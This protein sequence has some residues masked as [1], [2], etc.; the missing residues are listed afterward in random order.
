MGADDFVKRVEGMKFQEVGKDRRYVKA[1]KQ[2]GMPRM[3]HL[4]ALELKNHQ[5]L[6]MGFSRERWSTLLNDLDHYALEKRRSG[7][8]EEM[9]SDLHKKRNEER[10]RVD[11]ALGAIKPFGG[12][13]ILQKG[14]RKRFSVDREL[15]G[16]QRKAR[17][18]MVG[19]RIKVRKSQGSDQKQ[20][21][22]NSKRQG[23]VL[24]FP[25][26]IGRYRCPFCLVIFD[27]YPMEDEYGKTI[28]CI[29]A[30]ETNRGCEHK[31]DK[32]VAIACAEA[33]TYSQEFRLNEDIR[34]GRPLLIGIHAILELADVSAPAPATSP[35][36]AWKTPASGNIRDRRG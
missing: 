15:S 8:T 12:R 2:C 31:S 17:D 33:D 24:Q 26:L 20:I 28:E 23:K 21:V 22:T 1:H 9:I 19:A 36:W 29:L 5:F 4:F 6:L 30:H 11:Q 35:D 32:N 16:K 18:D 3:I 10:L 27:N 14:V 25:E 7:F 34:F 13:G